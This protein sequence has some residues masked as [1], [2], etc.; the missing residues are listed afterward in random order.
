MRG[1]KMGRHWRNEAI[2]EEEVFHRHGSLYGRCRRA[3]VWRRPVVFSMQAIIYLNRAWIAYRLQ[4]KQVT[5]TER[6]GFHSCSSALQPAEDTGWPSSVQRDI[7]IR[8]TGPFHCVRV[9]KTETGALITN[10]GLCNFEQDFISYW[11]TENKSLLSERPSQI[12]PG[13]DST[14]PE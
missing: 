3:I 11:N 14:F 1:G 4:N 5:S 12:P 8:S 10:C 7:D 6:L 2:R 13:D 9:T